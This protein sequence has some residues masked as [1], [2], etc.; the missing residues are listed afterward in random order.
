MEWFVLAVVGV[1][2]TALIVWVNLYALNDDSPNPGDEGFQSG[3]DG[4]NP[5][6]APDEPDFGKTPDE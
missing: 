3:P 2:F 5:E 1:G 6:T 4:A